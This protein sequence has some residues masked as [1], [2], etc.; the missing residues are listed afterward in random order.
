MLY[1]H[2]IFLKKILKRHEFTSLVQSEASFIPLSC[3]FQMAL[4]NKLKVFS[5]FGKERFTIR[6][7]DNIDQCFSFRGR[8]SQKLFNLVEKK[9]KNKSLKIA[10]QIQKQKLKLGFI[11]HGYYHV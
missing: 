4:K 5:R 6:K 11:W 2:L 8:I 1:I 7:Y 10:N 3:L 9:F